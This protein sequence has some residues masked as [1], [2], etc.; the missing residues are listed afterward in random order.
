ML[1][2]DQRPWAKP[3]AATVIVLTLVAAIIAPFYLRSI[4]HLDPPMAVLIVLLVLAIVPPNYVVLRR[5]KHQDGVQGD[6]G[7]SGPFATRPIR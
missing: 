7:H 5:Q 6:A 4:K 1:P 3:L 2:Y